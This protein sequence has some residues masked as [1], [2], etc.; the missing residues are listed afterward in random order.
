M[1][2]FWSIFKAL[3]YNRV[4]D[5]MAIFFT[6]F[7]PL[8]FLIVFGLAF[9]GGSMGGSSSSGNAA[10]KFG[11]FFESSATEELR[12]AVIDASEENGLDPREATSTT[13]L[14]EGVEKGYSGIKFGLSLGVKKVNEVIDD[15]EIQKDVLKIK[16]Y[17][18]AADK[19]QQALYVSNVNSLVTSMIKKIAGFK[20]IMKVDVNDIEFTPKKVTSMGYMMS[21]VLAISITFSGLMALIINFGYFRK[22][23]VLKRFLATPFKGS[24]F[25]FASVLNTLLVSAS[26]I[27]IILL[28]SRFAFKVDFSI[29]WVEMIVNYISSMTLM[30]AVGG[31]FLLVFR[32]PNAAMNVANVFSTIMMF[33]AGVYFPIQLMPDWLQTVAK[34]FPMTYVANNMR[35]VLGQ[36]TMAVS[37]FWTTNIVFLAIGLVVIPILG[38]SIFRKEQD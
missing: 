38:V 26:S 37:E 34:F 30:M 20:D 33:V 32:E 16:A 15:Q 18:D 5:K 24:I 27:V 4:R 3:F 28:V 8:L 17:Y 10:T 13:A 7:F 1:R 29:M 11:V 25:M 21:G 12:N 36:D 23:N 9:G 22:E 35:Y 14:M 31:L 19:Q 2:A 6:M